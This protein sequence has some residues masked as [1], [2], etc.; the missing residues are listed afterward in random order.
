MYVNM[1]MYMYVYVYIPIRFPQYAHDP[2]KT[3][4]EPSAGAEA[5]LLSVFTASDYCGCLEGN[6]GARVVWKDG[7]GGSAAWVQFLRGD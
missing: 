1:Y 3:T 6:A 5:L 7:P 4:P 2:I